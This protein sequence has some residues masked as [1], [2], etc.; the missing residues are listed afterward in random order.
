[1]IKTDELKGEIA[2]NGLSQSKVAERLGITP[3]T[4]YNK[5]KKGVFDSDEISAM[6]CL[7][8][9]EKP[10]PIFLKDKSLIK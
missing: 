8:K 6:I 5:M 3:K 10:M 2:K 7:L 4:F 1:M 9:I